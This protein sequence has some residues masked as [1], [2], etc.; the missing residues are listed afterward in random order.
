MTAVSFNN[1]SIV[2]GDRPETALAM[3]DQGKTRDEIGAATGLVLGV[4]NASLT[5]EEGEILVLMGSFRLRQVDA[6]ARRQ[7]ARSRGAWRC[8]GLGGHRPRQPL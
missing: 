7:R 5:I 8:R 2:F 4:A 6:A 1:V 3:V